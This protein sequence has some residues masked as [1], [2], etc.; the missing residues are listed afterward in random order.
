MPFGFWHCSIRR[1]V[2]T[3]PWDIPGGTGEL[4]EPRA[5]QDSPTWI[6]LLHRPSLPADT[7]RASIPARGSSNCLD[8]DIESTFHRF[9][10]KCVVREL[11]E[12]F[13]KEADLHFNAHLKNLKESFHV[14]CVI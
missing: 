3:Q 14:S 11:A 2:P 4:R 7:Q 13:N 10:F 9:A 5:S 8:F 6:V 1:F 12:V